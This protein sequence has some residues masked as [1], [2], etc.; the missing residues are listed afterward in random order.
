MIVKSHTNLKVLLGISWEVE[1]II[2]WV[3]TNKIRNVDEY[4]VGD[5][6]ETQAVV[7]I[8]GKR[9]F[10]TVSGEKSR[11]MNSTVIM[12]VNAGGLTLPHI[13]IFKAS[14][15]K[16]EWRE[17]I[18]FGHFIRGSASGYSNSKLFY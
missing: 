11:S 12:L 17:L 14:K 1:W 2:A 15:M 6:P 10:Q 9:E 4:G 3:C 5:A 16:P 18:P 13:I 7:G 8:T